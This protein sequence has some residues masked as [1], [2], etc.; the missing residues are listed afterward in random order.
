MTGSSHHP[1]HASRELR[2]LYVQ[3]EVDGKLAAM[4]RAAQGIRMQDRGILCCPA[5]TFL[6]QKAKSAN[7]PIHR[8][9]LFTEL[10]EALEFSHFPLGFQTSGGSGKTLI[11]GLPILLAA[12]A[13]LGIMTA[14]VRLGTVAGGFAAAANAGGD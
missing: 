6:I 4:T 13:K 8:R 3:F 10:L 1:S 5:T 7:L 2:V 12:Q 11:Y 9:Q 14:V